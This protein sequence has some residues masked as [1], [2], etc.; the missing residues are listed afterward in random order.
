MFKKG[1]KLMEHAIKEVIFI[2]INPSIQKQSWKI[3]LI[4]WKEIITEN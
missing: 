1:G 4:Q 3:F 2:S